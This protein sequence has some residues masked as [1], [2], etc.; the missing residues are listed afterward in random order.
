M[1]LRWELGSKCAAAVSIAVAGKCEMKEGQRVRTI[2]PFGLRPPE[3]CN[4]SQI[5]FAYF[6]DGNSIC[7][8][9]TPATL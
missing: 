1:H 6:Q 4:A 7:T 8:G 3:S 2:D 5:R 9:Y